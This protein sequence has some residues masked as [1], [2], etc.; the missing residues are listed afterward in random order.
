MIPGALQTETPRTL[1][2]QDDTYHEQHDVYLPS[3]S[4]VGAADML[5]QELS[6]IEFAG[7]ATADTVSPSPGVPNRITTPVHPHDMGISRIPETIKHGTLG[8]PARL[9]FEDAVKWK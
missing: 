2:L 9:A 1:T 7:H 8:P 6:Q 4:T 5:S 3:F